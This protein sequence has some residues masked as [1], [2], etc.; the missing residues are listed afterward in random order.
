TGHA[1]SEYTN[2]TTTQLI[3]A[4]TG[5]WDRRLID[6]LDLPW[7]WFADLVQPGT[8]LGPL[9]PALAAE[10]ELDGVRIVAPATHDTASAVAGAPLE[11]GWA[12]ISSGTWSLVGV[13]RKSALINREAA[14]HNF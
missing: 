9:K 14:R 4:E 1:V 5:A 3:N 10:L 7:H 6:L 11:K 2:A 8:D 12:Y 13:E